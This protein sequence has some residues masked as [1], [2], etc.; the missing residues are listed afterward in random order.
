VIRWAYHVDNFCGMVRKL[1]EN[2]FPLSV[3]W[4]RKLRLGTM[5]TQK[6]SLEL[7]RVQNGK[8]STRDAPAHCS[9]TMKQ[10]ARNLGAL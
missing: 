4:Q 5:T 7:V 2:P 6:L 8:Q 10:G 3:T 1:H 9:S